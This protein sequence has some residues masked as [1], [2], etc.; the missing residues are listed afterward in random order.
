MNVADFTDTLC[1]IYATTSINIEG[2]VPA[3]IL[4]PAEEKT[5]RS[6]MSLTT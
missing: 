6:V 4:K 5:H 3:E 1:D 2:G